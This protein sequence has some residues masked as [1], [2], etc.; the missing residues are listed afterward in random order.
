MG[1]K[2]G[3]LFILLGNTKMSG[4]VTKVVEKKWQLMKK[5]PTIIVATPNVSKRGE[6][7]GYINEAKIVRCSHEDG[8]RTCWAK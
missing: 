8:K 1:K 4:V 7:M 6:D 2:V 5:A 3:D